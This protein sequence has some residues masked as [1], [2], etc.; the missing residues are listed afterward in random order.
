MKIHFHI[1]TVS[2]N[3]GNRIMQTLDSIYKQ[4][5]WDY[6]VIIEDSESTDGSIE[7]LA[8]KVRDNTHIFV[9]KD[10]GIYDGM[11]LAL[12]HI[13]DIKAYTG[14]SGATEDTTV[15]GYLE[16]VTAQDSYHHICPYLS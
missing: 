1:I 12:S 13:E 8:D 3:S 10:K 5:Y 7:A 16:Y 9:K 2:Y 15:E 4:D 11:N 14:K 6:D